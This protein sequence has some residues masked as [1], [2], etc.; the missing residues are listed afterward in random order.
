MIL[1]RTTVEAGLLEK[2]AF[3]PSR[4]PPA[5]PPPPPPE[6]EPGSR[7]RSSRIPLP[8][9]STES[10]VRP[11]GSRASVRTWFFFFGGGGGG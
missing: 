10:R 6:G 3:A 2:P 11:V 4:R 1:P 7:R 9:L 8:D 5:P